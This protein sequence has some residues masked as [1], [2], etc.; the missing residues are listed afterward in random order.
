[1][2]LRPPS[3]FPWIWR[4]TISE[5]FTWWTARRPG[6]WSWIRRG[7]GSW[8]PCWRTR[9]KAGSPI[10][11]ESRWIAR[12]EST[13][14]IGRMMPFYDSTEAATTNGVRR[15][16]RGL[17]LLLLL[18]VAPAAR[19]WARAQDQTEEED[20]TTD[21]ASVERHLKRGKE[22]FNGLKFPEAIAEFDQVVQ[23]YEA[24]KLQDS[25]ES[26]RPVAEALELRARAYFNQGDQER[27]KADFASLLKV[28]INHAIDSK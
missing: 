8:P 26:Q 17:A 18:L 19:G 24:G 27:A 22:L 16:L 23:A 5:I 4:W 6:L 13:S 21:L 7:S 2:S 14:T 28:D 1:M 3:A 15:A 12:E 20:L 11:C 10:H 25:G 9:A